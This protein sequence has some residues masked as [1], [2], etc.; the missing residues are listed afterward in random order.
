MTDKSS[1]KTGTDLND[2]GGLRAR[3]IGVF[4]SGI[5]GL[6]VVRELRRCLPGE[7]ILYFGDTARVPYG[8]KSPETVIRFSRE[9][10]IFLSRRDVK[11]V[12]VA[13]NTASAIA[14]PVLQETVSVP[15]IGVILPGV[16]AALKASR[17]R[18]VGVVGTEAT[19]GSGAYERALRKA[20]GELFIAQQ[21]C[22]LFVP[23]AEEG[24][25]DGDVPHLVAHHYLDPVMRDGIDTLILGCTHYPMLRNVISQVVGA[26]I[27]LV[28]SAEETARETAALLRRTGAENPRAHGGI[29]RVF[30][31]DTAQRFESIGSAFLGEQLESVTVVD[32]SD[33]PWYER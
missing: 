16:A 20:D 17:S 31:S 3:P 13:C 8:T 26:S 12:V 7:D 33:L 27:R 4:D 21:S 10:L 14:L 15:M 30:V 6:T 5:G 29:C 25:V 11:L 18:R 22:P 32:Q 19:I 24:W 23:L 2:P 1:S 28:D 9:S